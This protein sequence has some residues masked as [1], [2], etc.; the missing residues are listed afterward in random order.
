ML[1]FGEHVSATLRTP[2]QLHQFPLNDDEHDDALTVAT[3][4]MLVHG[5]VIITIE[6]EDQAEVFIELGHRPK[7]IALL[8]ARPS[9][10][11]LDR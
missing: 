2:T 3:L 7:G 8:R 4:H 5:V 11:Q 9:H 1:L 10:N 6:Q